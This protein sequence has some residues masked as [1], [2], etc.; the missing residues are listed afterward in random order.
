ME[1]GKAY[2]VDERGDLALLY[3]TGTPLASPH[4]FRHIE[5]GWQLDLEGQLRSTQEAIGGRYSWILL[6]SGDDF[7][8]AFV[9]RWMPLRE[10]GYGT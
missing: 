5:A 2:A 7:H 6:E 9:D 10:R 1:Y 4:F 3:F 8:R